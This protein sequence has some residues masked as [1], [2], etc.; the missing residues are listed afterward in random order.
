MHEVAIARRLRPRSRTR[1]PLEVLEEIMLWV[2]LTGS[3]APGGGGGGSGNSGSRSGDARSPAGHAREYSVELPESAALD[4]DTGAGAALAAGPSAARPPPALAT[5]WSARDARS[6][7]S[8]ALVCREFYCAAVSVLW[9]DPHFATPHSLLRFLAALQSP[10]PA[11]VP[12][13]HDGSAALGRA[14]A[15]AAAA[16]R[17]SSAGG[18]TLNAAAEAPTTRA[19]LMLR[20]LSGS[21][22]DDRIQRDQHREDSIAGGMVAPRSHPRMPSGSNASSATNTISSSKII[23]RKRRA[24]NA[25][26]PPPAAAWAVGFLGRTKLR[27]LDLTRTHLMRDMITHPVL[28]VIADARLRLRHLS[29]A[30]CQSLQDAA[31]VHIGMAVAA[32]LESLDI[33][34]CWQITDAAV[35]LLCSAMQPHGRFATLRA[36]QVSQL[37]DLTVEALQAYVLGSLKCIDLSGCRCISDDAVLRLLKAMAR[38]VPHMHSGPAPTC[39]ACARAA[40]D[41]GSRVL[42]RPVNDQLRELRLPFGERVTRAGFVAIVQMLKATQPGLRRFHFVVPPAPRGLCVLKSLQPDFCE[43]L[44]ELHIGDAS[45]VAG[46]ALE[47][48]VWACKH[49]LTGLTIAQPSAAADATL[50]PRILAVCSRLQRLAL[51]GVSASHVHEIA[52]AL[53]MSPSAPRLRMLDLSDCRAM[54]DAFVEA[55][56]AAPMPFVCLERVALR[57]CKSL[58]IK[59]LRVLVAALRPPLGAL[60]HLD[61]TG[62]IPAHR[63]GAFEQHLDRA[64]Q[65]WIRAAAD[66][67]EASG[68]PATLK[69]RASWEMVP[70]IVSAADQD[71]VMSHEL[72]GSR[73][74]AFRWDSPA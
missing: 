12:V 72:F 61:L 39:A 34:Q 5:P 23:K 50:L 1:L 22:P 33:S 16:W 51:V 62:V 52:L 29:L 3:T 44:T 2:L 57:R 4:D 36:A 13:I 10:A 66:A 55:M 67:P 6:V 38:P 49:H 41:A 74:E 18:Q 63:I 24:G 11:A 54:R 30:R 20:K 53:R 35:V 31:L 9:R 42:E 15:A 46:A 27:A 73:L 21:L 60:E 28:A 70:A 64:C 19:S 17:R 14:E 32:T 48:A 59:G 65:A 8:C 25:A 47:Q 58:T 43:R 69:A 7:L 45:Q 37:S 71:I 40:K 68:P 56:V 26:K